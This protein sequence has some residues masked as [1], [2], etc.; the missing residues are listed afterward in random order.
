MDGDRAEGVLISDQIL[1]VKTI[2]S[3]WKPF[4]VGAKT[5]EIM[6]TFYT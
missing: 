2:L 6:I 3:F 5:L 1:V 4:L